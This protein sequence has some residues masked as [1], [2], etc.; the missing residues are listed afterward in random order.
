MT[1]CRHTETNHA[2]ASPA[3]PFVH[4]IARPVLAAVVG[5]RA[6]E[7]R[8]YRLGRYHLRPNKSRCARS[9]CNSEAAFV[10][11]LGPLRFLLRTALTEVALTAQ[12][13]AEISTQVRPPALAPRI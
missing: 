6:A 8:V 9:Q 13:P 2:L 5:K 4:L 3:G 12:R 7:T 10:I 11:S 1:E